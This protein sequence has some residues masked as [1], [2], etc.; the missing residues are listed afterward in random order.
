MPAVRVTEGRAAAC[1]CG[2]RAGAA[3]RGIDAKEIPYPIAVRVEKPGD[4]VL[5]LNT[6]RPAIWR[7]SASAA[8]R[9]VGV[10]LLSYHASTVEGL[11]PGTPIMATDF[12]S[13]MKEKPA[14]DCVRMQWGFSGGYRG[15]PDALVFDRQVQALTGRNIE[16]L[17]GAYKLKDIVLR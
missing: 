4:M 1:G 2:L 11:A 17:Q 5:V 14:P 13:R 3:L 9:V 15:G 16:S 6:Y 10:V 12:E 8:S 7:V